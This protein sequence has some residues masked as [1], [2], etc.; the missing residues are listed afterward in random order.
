MELLR[1]I[2]RLIKQSAVLRLG[3]PLLI[4]YAILFIVAVLTV[5]ASVAWMYSGAAD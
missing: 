1:S 5:A 3:Q 4:V 2:A